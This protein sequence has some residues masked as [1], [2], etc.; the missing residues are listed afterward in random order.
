MGQLAE[1]EA[2]DSWG[3]ADD[4]V[5]DEGEGQG[6]GGPAPHRSREQPEAECHGCEG[7]PARHLG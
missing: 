4:A 2:V 7:D 3:E 5:Q 1:A 6:E